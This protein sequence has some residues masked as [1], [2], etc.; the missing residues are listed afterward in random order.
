M[1][2]SE[3]LL[4]NE[5]FSFQSTLGHA[6]AAQNFIKMVTLI[7]TLETA[8]DVMSGQMAMR[9]YL[10]NS[11]VP[12]AMLVITI[13]DYSLHQLPVEFLKQIRYTHIKCANKLCQWKF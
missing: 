8:S 7:E 13:F 6:I 2:S 3:I 12:N 9:T 5:N 1:P 4:C 11:K 10:C